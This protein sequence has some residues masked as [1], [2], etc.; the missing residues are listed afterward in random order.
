VEKISWW[1]TLTATPSSG[2]KLASLTLD[3]ASTVLSPTVSAETLQYTFTMPDSEV[4]IGASFEKIPVTPGGGVGGGGAVAPEPQTIPAGSNGNTLSVNVTVSNNTARLDADQT[5]LQTL[6]ASSGT[7]SFDFTSLKEVNSASIP[8]SAFGVLTDAE[9]ISGLSIALPDAGLTFDQAALTAIGAAGSGD[10]TLKAAMLDT[11][12]LTEDQI[13]LVGDRP[14][15]DL[16][17]AVGNT[18]VSDFGTGTVQ[19]NM[20]YALKPGENPE[21]VVVWYLNDNNILEAITGQYD[22]ATGSVHFQTDHF[23]K[24]VI[25]Q[26]PF[27]DVSRKAWYFDSVSFAFANGLFS[28]TSNTGFTPE[29]SM[30]RSMLVTVLWRMEGEPTV[31]KTSE[32]SDVKSGQWYETA[33]AWAA[34]KGIVSGYGNGCFGSN[35]PITREQMAVILMGY[36]R[37]KGYDVSAGTNL[38]QF[39]DSASISS[40][41]KTAMQWANSGGQFRVLGRVH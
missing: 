41:A 23:S 8:A 34:E 18:Q 33:V 4:T 12:T 31:K 20:P 28:G 17:L 32:F 11:K 7:V 21:A 35:D 22:V 38:N 19:I 24:Y 1:R 36:A 14:V 3:P 40:W 27:E 25:G 9:K 30:T 29:A 5:T 15:L 10:I 39:T 13:A 6:R 26:L 16:T 37:L 2:Y